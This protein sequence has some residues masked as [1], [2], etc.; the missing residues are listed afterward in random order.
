MGCYKTHTIMKKLF[1]TAASIAFA[2]SVNAQSTFKGDLALNT[3]NATNN[4]YNVALVTN[5]YLTEN[6]NLNNSTEMNV[7]LE[8]IMHHAEAIVLVAMEALMHL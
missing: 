1:F 4:A 8:D 6:S 7:A 3:S 5:E 2:V